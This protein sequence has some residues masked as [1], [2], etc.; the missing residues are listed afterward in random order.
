M[1]KVARSATAVFLSFLLLFLGVPAVDWHAYADEAAQAT[2]SISVLSE[3]EQDAAADAGGATDQ[4]AAADQGE[5]AA[6]QEA[7]SESSQAEETAGVAGTAATDQGGAAV[8]AASTT[9]QATA[10]STLATTFAPQRN[11][12]K[13]TVTLSDLAAA[14]ALGDSITVE[15]T[16]SYNG[17]VTRD[18]KVTKSLSE[19]DTT[20]GSFEMDFADFGKF[21]VKSSI[22]KGSTTVKSFASQTVGVTADEYNIA[23]LVATMP[24]LL[25]S[26]NIWNWGT[27]EDGTTIPQIVG[28]ERYSQWNWDALPDGVYRMPYVSKAAGEQGINDAAWIAYV[29][30]LYELD[31]TSHFNFY[32]TD[33]H[34]GHVFSYVYDNGIPDENAT[35]NFLSDGSATYAVCFNSIYNVADPQSVHEAKCAEWST[36]KTTALNGGDYSKWND[37]GASTLVYAAMTTESN[38]NWIVPNSRNFV[39]GDADGA[40]AAE[41][42]G[43]V[44]SVN[45]V[46]N[47]S[48]GS[49]L[50]EM[51][52][53][54]KAEFKALLN[55]NDGYFSDAREQGKQIMLFIGSRVTNEPNFEQYAAFT[56]AFYGTDDYA[57]YYKGHPGTPTDQYPEKQEQ[58]DLLD[59]TDVDSTIAAE[60]IMFFNEDANLA[61][62]AST[63][64]ESAQAGRMFGLF[65]ESKDA[66]YAESATYFK[67]FNWYASVL[68]DTHRA[69]FAE[70][71]IDLSDDSYL[72][73]F[74]DSYIADNDLNYSVAAWDYPTR[75]IYYLQ[76]VGD[77]YELV[78]QSGGVKPARTIAD[79]TYIIHSADN[80]NQVLD[81]MGSGTEDGR[82]LA[83]Y[84]DTGA[85][86]QRFE[87]KYLDNGY[88]TL[89][90]KCSDKVIDVVASGRTNGTNVTQWTY[91]EGDN[92]QWLIQDAGDGY[93]R[94]VSKV[95]GKY[96]DIEGGH[97]GNTV[98]VQT[99]GLTSNNDGK[100]QLFRF[101][102]VIDDGY[103][104]IHSADDSNQ[105]LDVV[106]GFIDDGANVT[107]YHKTGARNQRFQVYRMGNGYYKIAAVHSWRALDVVAG[108]QDYGTNVT[109][110]A[111]YDTDNQCWILEPQTDG[112]YKIKSKVN[113]LYLDV[114]GGYAFDAANVWTWGDTDNNDAKGQCW[115]FERTSR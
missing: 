71:G 89:T 44:E 35:I 16:M 3:E 80:D 68:D 14:K 66:A 41:A 82:N 53:E 32:F 39:S 45:A 83:M 102:S 56:M 12:T 79:G 73:E 1:G 9:A 13:V 15:A 60:V 11:T 115:T 104:F 37:T 27:T 48:I 42:K 36:A 92:Q 57:Y 63:T 67:Q 76:K 62:Y 109:Q 61:G 72:I 107:T 108:G 26:M 38:V 21:T 101:E 25:Y 77:G 19:I 90:A 100:G 51:T 6:Y 29:N 78:G 23:P 105:V 8:E 84:Q 69:A 46:T 5:A 52:D 112:T 65:N 113:G 49:L 81:I 88:Y 75:T 74:N 58:L 30:D 28:L 24:V 98:N 97:A 50:K 47:V 20:T 33:Y 103:Y 96:L 111:Q 54:E 22:T 59:I 43:S 2:Q 91:H 55:F 70:A 85:A 40:F 17:T 34:A 99:W 93:F 86:N 31:N 110:W 4:G 95:S 18:V 114:Q 10:N 94:I 87:V 64:F 106:A 7:T